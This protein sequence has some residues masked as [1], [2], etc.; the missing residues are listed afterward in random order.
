MTTTHFQ[1]IIMAEYRIP[2]YLAPHQLRL[3]SILT[4]VEGNVKVP[5]SHILYDGLIHYICHDL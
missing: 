1:W 3:H 5:Y 4:R 2:G